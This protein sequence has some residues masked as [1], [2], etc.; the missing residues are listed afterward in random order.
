MNMYLAR[1]VY[2]IVASRKKFKKILHVLISEF[3]K[4]IGSKEPQLYKHSLESRLLEN[5]IAND[6]RNMVGEEKITE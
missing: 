2:N 6:M 1:R 4:F 3:G 5:K